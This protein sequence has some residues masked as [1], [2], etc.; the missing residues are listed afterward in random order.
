MVVSAPSGDTLPGKSQIAA[1][2]K[3]RPLLRLNISVLLLHMMITLVFVQFP[4]NLQDLGWE[5]SQHWMLY[6]PVLLLIEATALV[7]TTILLTAARV[8]PKVS[9]PN[10]YYCGIVAN[11]GGICRSG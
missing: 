10:N 1:M 4:V 6:L 7:A 3:S 5:L 9:N 2:L 11:G 8:R